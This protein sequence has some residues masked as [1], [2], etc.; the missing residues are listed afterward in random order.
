MDSSS[1]A[2]SLMVVKRS[3]SRAI[4][5]LMHST[6]RKWLTCL[7]RSSGVAP[8]A[9]LASGAGLALALTRGV[10]GRDSSAAA[11]GTPRCGG[12]GCLFSPP[13]DAPPHG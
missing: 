12:D 2:S 7:S 3:S 13:L 4:T 10:A 5:S 9:P 1:S 11:A 6:H 8:S